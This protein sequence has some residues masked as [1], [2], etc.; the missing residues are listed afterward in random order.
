LIRRVNNRNIQQY[1]KEISTISL[2]TKNEE[3]ICAR[4]ARQGDEECRK[5]MI[6]SNLR[7]VVS[8]AKKYL[9]RGLSLPDLINAGNYGLI[10]A[11]Y[12][13]DERKKVRF[14]TYAV[15]WIRKAIYDAISEEQGLIST[16]ALDKKLD[17]VINQL[18]H[19]LGREPDIEDIACALGISTEEVNLTHQRP[20]TYI[21][22]DQTVDEEDKTP[23]IELVDALT[24]PSPEELYHQK[25]LQAT[26]KKHLD[27]LKR[28]ER[29]IIE[30]SFGIGDHKIESID[31]ISKSLNLTREKVRLVREQALRK[32]RSIIYKN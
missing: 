22:L 18:Y 20:L 3:R 10:E 8:V 16:G 6:L 31:Q 19:R 26:I 17:Q 27:I 23:W 5:R 15:W 2:L 12:R 11:A 14:L 32:L 9:R 28:F 7:F 13:Y 29:K 24:I 30:R 4:K 25:E 1:F 21:S